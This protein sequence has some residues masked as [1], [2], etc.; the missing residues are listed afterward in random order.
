MYALVPITEYLSSGFIQRAL[1]SHNYLC[2]LIIIH[3]LLRARS[4]DPEYSVLRID[5]VY[6]MMLLPWVGLLSELVCEV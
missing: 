5:R 4:H 2:F 6:Y 3:L 1:H